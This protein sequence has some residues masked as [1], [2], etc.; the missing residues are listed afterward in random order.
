MTGHGVD[1]V[2]RGVDA[3]LLPT[4]TPRVALFE[5]WY[6]L[7]I[8]GALAAAAGVWFGFRA[9]GRAAPRLA[10]YLAATFAADLTLGFLSEASPQMTWITLLAIGGDCARRRGAQPI[11]HHPPLGGRPRA[12]LTIIP[13]VS[14]LERAEAELGGEEGAIGDRRGRRAPCASPIRSRGRSR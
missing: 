14:A 5:I 11:P 7:G 1:T 2:V 6:E 3:G 12:L 13:G 8:L 4:M 9:I 10:P